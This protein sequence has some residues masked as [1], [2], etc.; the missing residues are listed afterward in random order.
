MTPFALRLFA[1]QNDLLRMEDELSDC[2]SRWVGVDPEEDGLIPFERVT[3]DYYDRSFELKGAMD[4]LS[5][6]VEAQRQAAELGF[7][8]CW[9]CHLDGSETYYVFEDEGP[10]WKKPRGAKEYTRE[11]VVRSQE[12]LEE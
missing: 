4:S 6:P 1:A 3:Y 12:R 10:G 9:L 11:C 8:R 5:L 2:A 7:Q